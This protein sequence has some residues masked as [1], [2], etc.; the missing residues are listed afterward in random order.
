M[1]GICI[2]EADAKPMTYKDVMRKTLTEAGASAFVDEDEEIEKKKSKTKGV[3]FV[4]EVLQL[5]PH[6]MMLMFLWLPPQL[7]WLRRTLQMQQSTML[8]CGHLVHPT[9]QECVVQCHKHC[10]CARASSTFS[11]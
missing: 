8:H 3:L 6:C 4:A 2:Q 1:N 10:G 11:V 7:P 5:S 9:V